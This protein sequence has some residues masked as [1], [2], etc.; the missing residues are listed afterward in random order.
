MSSYI[1]LYICEYGEEGQP[2][3]KVPLS[4]NNMGIISPASRWW[5]EPFMS[6]Q[7]V[8]VEENCGEQIEVTES[9]DVYVEVSLGFL[10]CKTWK[11]CLKNSQ[12]GKV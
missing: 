8:C 10:D 5:G 9:F 7:S 3:Y 1:I 11:I 2:C 6:L 4:G 12:G